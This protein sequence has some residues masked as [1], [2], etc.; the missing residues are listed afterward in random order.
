MRRRVLYYR[1]LAPIPRGV[2]ASRR[3]GAANASLRS[4]IPSRSWMGG[5]VREH[6]TEPLVDGVLDAPSRRCG[7]VIEAVIGRIVRG[8]AGLLAPPRRAIHAAGRTRFG[9]GAVFGSRGCHL[10]GRL[11][12][13]W[14]AVGSGRRGPGRSTGVK[15]VSSV[16]GVRTVTHA[17]REGKHPHIG[18][19]APSVGKR[20]R[21][22][23][24]RTDGHT[25]L[26][27]TGNEGS[28]AARVRGRIFHGPSL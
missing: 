11:R 21:T 24:R 15:G 17:D 20:L 12:P 13:P 3:P 27:G 5:Q 19:S 25:G 14:L 9:I 7:H 16:T 4:M 8:P 6:G 26:P 18:E 10:G 23:R 28:P 2:P 22:G 1:C